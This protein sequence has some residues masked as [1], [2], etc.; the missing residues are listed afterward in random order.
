MAHKTLAIIAVLSLLGMA[1]LVYLALTFETPE[2]TRTVELERPIPRP[3]E[4][5]LPEEFP[6]PVDQEP[7]RPVEVVPEP[8]PA[9]EPAVEPTE[10]AESAQTEP[11]EVLPNLNSSDPYV[12]QRLASM[13]LGASLLRLMVS[14]EI[15]RKFVVFAHNVAEGDLPQLE[16]PL[17]R[18]QPEFMVRE[19]DEN[20]YELD[21]ASYR[22]YNT[23]VDTLVAVEPGQAMQLYDSLQP[24]FQEAYQE[25]GYQGSFAQVLVQAIDQILAARPLEGPFQLI[26]PSVMYVF[27]ESE[28][29]ALSPVE[30][31]LLRMG[32]ENAAKLQSRLPAYR[33]RL[34]AG[35]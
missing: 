27:A 31:Q 10:I 20:L 19:L 2:A 4:R 14:D 34:Q 3:I 22:R 8:E 35:R 1:F 11:P 17:R 24:L 7:F 28:L 21:P 32:P 13:E 5:V 9:P 23:L 12:R 16:Y 33:E 25:L 15:I 6:A 30:K 26:K 18:V 29:E